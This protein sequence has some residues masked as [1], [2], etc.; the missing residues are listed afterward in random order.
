MKGGTSSPS[1]PPQADPASVGIVRTFTWGLDIARS[2][3]DSGGV[4][5]LVQLADHATGKTF[6]PTYDGNGNILGQRVLRLARRRLRV[7][8][9]GEALRVNVV[10]VALADQPFRFDQVD[11]RRNRLGVLRTD[12]TIPEMA[13]SS[14]GIR[15]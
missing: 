14:A 13:A 11:R 5:A 3:S 6:I 8:P 2:L 4:G 9:L 15:S 10:D 7:Q 12:F 1:T